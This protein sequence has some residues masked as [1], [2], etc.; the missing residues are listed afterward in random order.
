MLRARGILN[1]CALCLQNVSHINRKMARKLKSRLRHAFTFTCLYGCQ[2]FAALSW[3]AYSPAQI[4]AACLKLPKV[5]ASS[6]LIAFLLI[7]I[8]NT[9]WLN[10]MWIMVYLLM[11]SYGLRFLTF[12]AFL[13][14]VKSSR[15]FSLFYAFDR[16]FDTRGVNT[17]A[18]C[19]LLVQIAFVLIRHCRFPL[20][21]ID[22]RA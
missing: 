16:H 13:P 7:I 3:R 19:F 6:M 9:S 22:A 20:Y 4:F 5:V 10:F 12:I 17:F 15:L 8:A 11:P 18:L 2:V 14:I 21:Y 1:F